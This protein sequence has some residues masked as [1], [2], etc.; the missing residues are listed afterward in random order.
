[1]GG[2][3]VDGAFA[4]RMTWAL[5]ISLLVNA[6]AFSFAGW[7][8]PAGAH[9]HP[10]NGETVEIARVTLEESPDHHVRPK[11]MPLP[12]PTPTPRATPMPPPPSV[13]AP[14]PNVIH[15]PRLPEVSAPQ[16]RR[17]DP[18]KKT[19]VR[20]LAALPEGARYR[21]L[22]A[23]TPTV[24]AHD[25]VVLG[26]GNAHL[27]APLAQESAGNATTAPDNGAT[28]PSPAAEPVRV[29]A[30]SPTRPSSGTE[31]LGAHAVAHAAPAPTPAAPPAPRI[32]GPTR[33]AEPARQVQP[34][35]PD[36]LRQG[37]FKS[38]VR[39]RVSVDV[40]GNAT[41]VLRTSSG[42]PEVDQRV[43]SA[44]EQWQWKPALKSGVPVESTLNFKFEFEV[45]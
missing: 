32:A 45:Q 15:A 5:G 14:E 37:E 17:P 43:L 10:H 38:F 42:N 11:V 7:Y 21:I 39:V 18:A 31:G 40:S 4:R 16:D 30:P 41:Y 25:H 13:R 28:S 29:S 12:R 22:T 44:L 19:A 24:V 2:S 33:D 35:I 6:A 34:T 26:G 27:G 36:T 23:R 1:M 20:P 8:L 9:D 3:R